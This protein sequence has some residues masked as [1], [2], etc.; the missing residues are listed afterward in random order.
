[1]GT[2]VKK[3]RFSSIPPG[4]FFFNDIEYLYSKF[5]QNVLELKAIEKP[6]TKKDPA[7]EPD[8]AFTMR[9]PPRNTGLI[10]KQR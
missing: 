8:P 6:K 1:V 2:V 3:N 4:E 5:T 7:K 10:S 9:C